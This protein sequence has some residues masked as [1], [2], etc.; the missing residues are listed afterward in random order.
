MNRVQVDFSRRTGV[1]RPLH[2]VNNGP[3]T[4]SF[5]HNTTPF[6]VEAGIPSVRL[7]DTE[8]PYG[9][10]HFVDVPCVFKDFNADPADPAS[11][12]FALTDMY[13]QAIVD[14]GARVFYRLGVSIE[15]APVKR[16]IYPPKDPCKWARICEGIVRHYNEGWADGFHFGIEYWEIWN[17]PE[18]EGDWLKLMWLGSNEEFFRLYAVAAN[19]LKKCFPQIK[20]GGYASCGFYGALLPH[21]TKNQKRFVEFA[22]QFFDYISAPATR[23]PLDFFSWHLYSD[24][25]SLYEAAGRHVR[26]LL[27]RRGF[28]KA[29][30]IL[31]EWNYAGEGMFDHMSTEVGAA[32]NAGALCAMQHNRVDLA[33][34]YDAQPAMS[35][36]GLFHRG[37]DAPTKAFYALKAWNE[38]RKLG[39]ECAA[40]SDCPDVRVCAARDGGRAG[41]LIS[42]YRAQDP[43]LSIAVEGFSPRDGVRATFY[44]I[45]GAHCFEAVSEERFYGQAMRFARR[46][47]GPATLYIDF[48]TL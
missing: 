37:A 11:Y 17:E 29:E 16:N 31:D 9:S 10:G 18:G 39:G 25:L 41:L 8:Y 33:H 13:I 26:A 35:Y 3:R 47:E 4:Y 38:L 30:S 48:Q 46:V 5:F 42:H 23:A 20:V 7:H 14:C 34:Y 24:D 28:A 44:A 45:D 43:Q 40:Q 21:P 1:I 6:F 12:D 22:D 27:D 15:H 19:R 32:L 36:C 2:G